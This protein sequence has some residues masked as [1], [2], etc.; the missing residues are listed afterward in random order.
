MCLG[1]VLVL[2]VTS[3]QMANP[4]ILWLDCLTS[5]IDR[6]I[7]VEVFL[8]FRTSPNPGKGDHSLQESLGYQVFL[9]TYAEGLHQVLSFLWTSDKGNCSP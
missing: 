7:L 1:F 3:I 2:V 9:L 6:R 4:L 5:T 8:T